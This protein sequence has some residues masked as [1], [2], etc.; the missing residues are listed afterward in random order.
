MPLRP[1]MTETA[2]EHR[3][4]NTVAI[5]WGD[6]APSKMVN[7]TSG[8]IHRQQVPHD[9]PAVLAQSA[10]PHPHL[11]FEGAHPGFGVPFVGHAVVELRTRFGE[12]R[13]SVANLPRL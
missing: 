6:V 12:R 9:P 7:L 1:P 10:V 4:V 13:H 8:G 3:R 2:E 11:P 5:F